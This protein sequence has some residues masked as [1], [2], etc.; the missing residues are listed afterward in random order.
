LREGTG[1]IAEHEPSTKS[2]PGTPCRQT[3]RSKDEREDNR[4]PQ[5]AFERVTTMTNGA[6]HVGHI[7]TFIC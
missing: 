6:S 1:R 3:L 5:A 4:Q 2:H 7:Q